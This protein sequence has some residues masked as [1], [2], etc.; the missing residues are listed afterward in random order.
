MIQ[1]LIR[2]NP[3]PRLY[4]STLGDV[5]FDAAR[6]PSELTPVMIGACQLTGMA[7]HAPVRKKTD[8]P[9][10]KIPRMFSA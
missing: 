6:R 10:Q 7:A 3:D 2:V 5:D 8:L 4:R 9:D 1:M